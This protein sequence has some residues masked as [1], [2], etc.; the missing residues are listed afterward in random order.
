MDN[1]EQ[2][3]ALDTGGTMT[4]SIV[5]EEDGTYTV[6]K[7]QSTPDNEYRGIINSYSDVLKKNGYT[8]DEG[9]E[10]LEEIVYTGTAMLNRLVERDGIGNIGLVT[11]KGFEDTHRMGRGIQSWAG[12]SYAGRLHAR[13]HEHPEPIVPRENIEGVSG[14]MNDSGEEVV[15]LYE[16][17]AREAVRSL[18][19]QGVRVICVCFVYSYKNPAHEKQFKQIAE[20]VKEEYDDDTPI[21]LSINQ[22][23]VRGELPRLNSLVLEAYAVE[24]SREQLHTIRDS[25]KER[26]STASFRVLT[27]SGEAIS[28]D[29][30]WLIDT[31]ISGPIGGMFGGEYLADQLGMSNLVC[32]DVGGTSFEVG[33]ITEGY[34]PTRWDQALDQFMLNIPMTA[35]DTIGSGTGS[36]IRLDPASDRIKVGPDSAGYQVGVSNVDSGLETP[37]ITDCA[38]ALGYINPDLFLGGRIDIDIDR[39]REYIA[40]QIANP[41]DQDIDET[42]RGVIDIVE[43]N[44][45][46]ELKS[47]IFGLGFSPED[48]NLVSYGGGGP[49]HAAGY[50]APLDFKDILIPSWASAFSAFGSACTD[51]AYREDQTVE[52]DID[53]DFEN[54]SDVSARLSHIFESLFE[55]IQDNF[56]R[57][58]VDASEVTFQPAVHLQYTGM[59]EDLRID[60]PS[61]FWEQGIDE[62]AIRI[63]IEKYEQKFSKIFQQVA[64]S[65]ERGY[66]VTMVTGVGSVETPKPSLPHK[67]LQGK[68]PSSEA[69]KGDRPIYVNDSWQDASI[70]DM[71]ELQPGNEIEG[72]AILEAPA[73]TVFVPPENDCSMDEHQIFHLK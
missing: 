61:E 11:N 57:D 33:L 9:T 72:P 25:F 62:Q 19:E 47:M 13:E 7:A 65:P 52:I 37:T 2:I 41:L 71:H 46:T 51:Y 60:I 50:T 40:D 3:L 28:P 39:A 34:Y 16:E 56:N 43:Q 6:G 26:G 27:A 10:N 49:L 14:R 48:Y 12:L 24:P 58:G 8:V 70:W 69:D 17:E 66:T 42:A 20:E 4:D 73:T 29:H 15:P 36:F 31:M 22:N 59:L 35:L 53:S 30:D 18:L 54:L 38:A 67:S 44:M 45:I 64:R 32:T 1:K 63:A 68:T 5:L 23:P 21:W 55:E